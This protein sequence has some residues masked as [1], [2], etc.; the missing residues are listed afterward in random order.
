MEIERPN[1]GQWRHGGSPSCEPHSSDLSAI[2]ERK[3][4]FYTRAQVGERSLAVHV[5][6]QDLDCTHVSGALSMI[7]AFARRKEGV[8]LPATDQ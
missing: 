7:G 3:R 5:A 8:P 4:I 2:G 6:T 1:L